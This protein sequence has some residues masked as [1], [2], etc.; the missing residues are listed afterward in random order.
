MFS[1]V[2]NYLSL[3][4]RGVHRPQPPRRAPFSPHRG[5]TRA[6]TG[7]PPHTATLAGRAAGHPRP[8]RRQQC[9][10]GFGVYP[11]RR[12]CRAPSARRRPLWSN[13]VGTRGTKDV[14]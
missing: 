3:V 10:R 14:G 9:N 6:F 1:G 12:V 8:E 7:A 2:D 13:G 4:V 5:G 11:A